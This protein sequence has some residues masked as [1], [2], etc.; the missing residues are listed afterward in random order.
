NRLATCGEVF[1][2]K[3]PIVRLVDLADI[4]MDEISSRF[5]IHNIKIEEIGL[6]PGEKMEESLMSSEEER[7]MIE[8]EWMYII[9][10]AYGS[11]KTAYKHT[12]H[13]LPI[14]SYRK[15]KV[16]DKE[17]LRTLCINEG[18]L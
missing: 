14:S 12:V 2:L 18:L 9:P 5:S 1:V 7:Q 16:I 8:T 6:R 15:N 17:L 11:S 10:P 4:I 3:M 13:F